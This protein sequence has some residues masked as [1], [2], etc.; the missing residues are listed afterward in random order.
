MPVLHKSSAGTTR[1]PSLA[2][3][4]L[5]SSCNTPANS[6]STSAGRPRMLRIA[7]IRDTGGNLPH[8]APS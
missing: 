5:S 4:V 7:W 2:S 6:G 3:S 1:G 8:R